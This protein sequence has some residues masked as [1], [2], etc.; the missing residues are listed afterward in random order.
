MTAIV[1]VVLAL[2]AG[3]AL[4]EWRQRASSRWPTDAEG[5]EDMRRR[6]V[7]LSK[8]CEFL[9]HLHFPSR[10]VAVEAQQEMAREGYEAK[11]SAGPGAPHNIV[12]VKKSLVPTEAEL[13]AVHRHLATLSRKYGGRYQGWFGSGETLQ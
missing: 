11:V 12:C 13:R 1:A 6:G 10:E 5:L 8:P 9:F 2:V 3:F 4:L 7:D